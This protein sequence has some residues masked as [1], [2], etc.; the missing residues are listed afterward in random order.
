[1]ILE[2]NKNKDKDKDKDKDKNKDKN[3]DKQSKLTLKKLAFICEKTSI[4]LKRDY[5]LSLVTY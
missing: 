5:K 4:T 2:E 3:K 1:M